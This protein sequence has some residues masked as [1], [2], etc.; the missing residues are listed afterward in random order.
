MEVEISMQIS[1]SPLLWTAEPRVSVIGDMPVGLSSKI[2][3]SYF[4]FETIKWI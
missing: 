4:I 3:E 2:K 1:P